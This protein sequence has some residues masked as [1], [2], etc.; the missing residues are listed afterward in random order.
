MLCA[1]NLQASKSIDTFYM[2]IWPLGPSNGA[3]MYHAMG[4]PV[5][6]MLTTVMHNSPAVPEGDGILC[7]A[8]GMGP[9]RGDGERGQGY[10]KLWQ[11]VCIA[12]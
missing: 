4:I 7:S 6:G 8:Q 3:D 9:G 12:P 2:L 11:Q 10:R 5:A 1:R